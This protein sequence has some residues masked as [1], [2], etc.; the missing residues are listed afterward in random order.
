M[1]ILELKNIT[2]NKNSVAGLCSSSDIAE[3]I[4]VSG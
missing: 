2:K 1:K 4:L 3:E